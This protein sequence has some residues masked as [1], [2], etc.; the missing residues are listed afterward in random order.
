M[1]RSRRASTG[2]RAMGRREFL[3][4]VGAAGVAAAAPGGAL[5][6][7]APADSTRTP[8]AAPAPGEDPPSADA[9]AVV[10]ILQRRFPGRLDPAQWDE[11]AK[12]VDQRLASGRR[13]GERVLDNGVEPDTVFRP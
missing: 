7:G 13:L 10:A 9:R 1:T 8:A 12:Q 6:A 11:V 2:A 5:A 3:A 4:L